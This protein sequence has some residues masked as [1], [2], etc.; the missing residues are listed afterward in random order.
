M[1]FSSVLNEAASTQNRPKE[2]VVPKAGRFSAPFESWRSLGLERSTSY[3][4][5]T[6]SCRKL[7]NNIGLVACFSV[8]WNLIKCSSVSFCVV[9]WK[10]DHRNRYF[11][12]A[13]LRL[14]HE[15]NESISQSSAFLISNVVTSSSALYNKMGIPPR[16]TVC[17]NVPGKTNGI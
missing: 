10:T 12:K 8:S 13:L 3:I 2:H 6:V 15:G 1:W 16:T 17:F 9:L 4:T 5:L 11:L 14:Q 7:K